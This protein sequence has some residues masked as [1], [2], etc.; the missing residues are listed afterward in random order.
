MTG[1]AKQSIAPRKERMA[2]FVAEFI[3]GPAQ[4]GTRWLFAMTANPNTTPRSRGAMG[5][6][7]ARQCPSV[8]RGRRE[9]RVPAAPTAS[10]ANGKFKH[11]SVV[12][13]GSDGSTGIP[14]AMVLT[15]Y[16]V[17]SP[18]TNS[19]CHR[20]QRI[21][22]SSNPVGLDFASASLAPATGVGTT[23]LCRPLKRRSSCTPLTAHE[24]H[25][26]L[27]LPLRA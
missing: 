3:I 25:L 9:C 21:K 17:L 8:N 12:T 14:R 20:H 1:S 16:S 22:G 5:P 15:A 11:T 24:V 27:R 7:F 10:R 13:T 23:R 18:A 2:C 4:G 6:S 19:S 26:A